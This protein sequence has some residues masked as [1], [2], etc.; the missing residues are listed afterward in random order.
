M[1]ILTKVR[2]IYERSEPKN[3][4]LKYWKVVKQWAKVKYNLG[5]A[6]IEMMLFLYSE[7][8]FNQKQFE[9]Y[10]EIMSWDKNRFHNLMKDK[11]IVVWR[12]RKGKESTLYELGFSGKRMCA[13]IYKK[14]NMEETVSEDRRLNPIFNPNADYSKKVYRKIIKKMNK[15]VK[16]NL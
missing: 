5:T 3:D 7:G 12:K 14:L 10:T 6:D 4:Y 15:E 13:S 2:K 16:K 8:L 11:W 9:E 1:K